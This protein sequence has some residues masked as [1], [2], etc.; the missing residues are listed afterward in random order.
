FTNL[1]KDDRYAKTVA[2]LR[3]LLHAR[4][5]AGAQ[6]G[7]AAPARAEA[8]RLAAGKNPGPG[9]WIELTGEK[10]LDVWRGPTKG[11]EIVGDAALNPDNAR[12]LVGRSGTGVIFNGPKG[13]ARD[14]Y[15]REN[16]GDIEVHLEF[17][18]PRGSNSGVKFEG[19]YEIQIADS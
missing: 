8:V 3:Q 17:L 4:T 5:K 11:W 12:Q 18:I 2:E 19:I 10:W 14:L 7:T 15:T 9:G 6:S 16:F 13:R 1:A